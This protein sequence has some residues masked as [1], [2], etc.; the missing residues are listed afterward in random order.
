MKTIPL[1]LTR[2]MS[3]FDYLISP[4]TQSI[5]EG[6]LINFGLGLTWIGDYHRTAGIAVNPCLTLQANEVEFCLPTFCLN[7][8]LAGE[9]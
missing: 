1:P 4:G 6:R 5:Q 3:L 8:V 2:L 7:F 9:L